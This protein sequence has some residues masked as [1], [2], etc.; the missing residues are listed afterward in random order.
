[1]AV[2]S[3]RGEQQ[4]EQQQ[5]VPVRGLDLDAITRIVKNIVVCRNIFT[6]GL[7]YSTWSGDLGTR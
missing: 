3:I 5:Q 4:Q 6:L 7:A 2:C 1:M